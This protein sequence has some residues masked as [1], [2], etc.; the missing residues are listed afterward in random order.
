MPNDTA[1]GAPGETPGQTPNT[2]DEEPVNNVPDPLVQNLTR[3]GQ[4]VYIRGL[5][6]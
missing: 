2:D 3:L 4:Q 5:G 6:G 1:T